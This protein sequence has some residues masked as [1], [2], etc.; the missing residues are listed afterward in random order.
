MTWSRARSQFRMLVGM[1]K[2]LE[3]LVLAEGRI[4][5]HQ[6]ELM[7]GTNSLSRLGVEVM[8]GLIGQSEI[9]MVEVDEEGKPLWFSRNPDYLVEEITLSRTITDRLDSNSD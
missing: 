8:M 7:S 5:Y 3:Q 1:V 4:S 6:M 9:I 2:E